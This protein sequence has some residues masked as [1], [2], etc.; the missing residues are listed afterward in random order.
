MRR[1]RS[2]IAIAALGFPG[3]SAAEWLTGRGSGKPAKT[4][5]VEVGGKSHQLPFYKF[6][7]Q[8]TELVLRRD[9]EKSDYY[10]LEA[11]LTEYRDSNLY[12]LMLDDAILGEIYTRGNKWAVGFE[13]LDLAR[14][15]LEHLRKLHKLKPEQVRDATKA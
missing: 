1:F 3:S 10:W 4:I 15:C 13:S 9:T 7:L 2:I 14:P 8:V 6:D 12:Y 11:T 5:T